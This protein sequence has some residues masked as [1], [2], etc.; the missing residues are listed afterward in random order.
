MGDN[1]TITKLVPT[2]I[3]LLTGVAIAIAG[4]GLHS[5]AV[6]N[7]GTAWAWGN[8]GTGQLGDTTTTQRKAPVQ[9]NTI[10]GVTAVSAG[11]N[12]SMALKSDNTVWTWG[13]NSSGELG[14]GTTNQAMAPVQAVGVSGATE[15][16]AGNNFSVARTSGDQILTWGSEGPGK[17]GDGNS[18]IR[19][20]P[21]QISGLSGVTQ[22]SA[23]GFHTLA[24]LS[25]GTVKALGDNSVGQLGDGTT[26]NRL[27]PVSV[28]G[29]TSITA[30]SAGNTHSL[31]RKNDGTV[32]AWGD[33]SSGQLGNNTTTQQLVP[34]QVVGVGGTGFLTGIA[35]ISASGS[36][37]YSLAVDS[38]GVVY[39][40]GFNGAG[41]LGDGTTTTRQAPVAVTGL[42]GV[43]TAVA[44]GNNHSLAL[45]NDGTVWA[46]GNNFQGQ[47][48]DGTVTN[49]LVPV[50]VAG[51]TGITA[52]S[53]GN[54]VSLAR[55][56]DGSMWA[57]G[58]NTAGQLGLGGIFQQF[59]PAENQNLPD[60]VS[61]SAGN[62]YSLFMIQIGSVVVG[63]FGTNS[64]GQLGN[65]TIG[66]GT[67]N[68]IPIL[69]FGGK[70]P[71][72]VSANSYS[73]AVMTDGTVWGWG[74]DNSG[75]LGDS[76][77]IFNPTP[78]APVARGVAD[79]TVTKS[80]GADFSAGSP[81]TYTITV[82]NVGQASMSGPTTVVDTLPAG[83]SFSSGSG[84][85]WV[86][87]GVSVG[88]SC[89]HS[90]A[91]GA[92]ASSVITLNVNT[93]AL[94]FPD[95]F[96]LVTVS[97]AGDVH[98]LNNT[99]SDETNAP[100]PT[101]VTLTP[102][103]SPN[104]SIFG[105][106][107]SLSATVTPSG[108]TGYV[109]FAD[110]AT[111][112]GT[113]P[114]SSGTAHLNTLLMTPGTRLLGAVFVPDQPYTY[115]YSPFVMHTVN[116][117]PSASLTP[118]ASSPLVLGGSRVGYLVATGDFN[119][120][121][122]MDI[123][124]VDSQSHTVTIYLGNGIGGFTASS[125]G[126]FQTGSSPVA[127]LV[128]DLNRDGKPD[129]AIANQGVNTLTVLFG[130]GAGGFA[131]APR[132]PFAVGFNPTSLVVGNINED[133]T[134]V[135]YVAGLASTQFTRLKRD[136]FGNFFTDTISLPSGSRSGIAAADFNGD[137]RFDVAFSDIAGTVGILLKADTDYNPLVNITS[138]IHPQGI[139]AADLNGDGKMDLVT[140]DATGIEVLIGNGSGGF[141][142]ATGSPFVP[143]AG[144][145]TGISSVSIGDFNGDGKPDLFVVRTPSSTS[146]GEVAIMLGNGSGGFA[147]AVGSGYASKSSN[148]L[149]AVVANFNGDGRTDVAVTDPG[150]DAVVVLQGL[151][152]VVA[153]VSVV[154]NS[155]AGAL[156][157]FSG[158]YAA[159]KGY[160]DLQWVQML[161]GATTSSQPYCLVHYDVQGNKFWLFNDVQGFFAG[162]ISPGVASNLLQGS[163]CALNTSGSSVSESGVDLTINAA[164]VFKQAVA[165]K[166]FMRGLTFEGV[167]TGWVQQGT[168]T[169]VAAALGTM[170]VA[171][172]SGSVTHGTQ[173]IFTLTY[174]DPPGFAGAA[175]GWEQF[176]VATATDGGG[177]PFCYVHYDRGG[178]GL[179]MYSGDVGYFLGPVTPGTASSLLTSSACSI[180]TAGATVA[181]TSGNLV[182]TVPVTFKAPMVRGNKLFQRTLDVLN[183]D[184][185]FEQTG[186]WTVN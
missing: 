160:R 8:N 155:G 186:T 74:F 99:A 59:T 141:T 6:K 22:A 183:R 18:D 53:A 98:A 102:A 2:Q 101:G 11:N 165:V 56:S 164:V 151:P 32:W 55:K 135:V 63:G 51:L 157:T 104:P 167:D 31:A 17:L 61:V 13:D 146:K 50:Q 7:D 108:A 43:F 144:S 49:H 166:I 106:N 180:N 136:M 124:V 28:S 70:T 10:T 20:V 171:P 162:P 129:L 178:N 84:T 142:E 46:W 159:A 60:V 181:N 75:Q 117:I 90:G 123:A 177:N 47:L 58:A 45:R 140:Y 173:Q 41:Q 143:G 73:L 152:P 68:P 92:G 168:W 39:A 184:T 131:P 72:S 125:G 89:T 120:D 29:I 1:T 78:T 170:T 116:A 57:W 153:P 83:M 94:M 66:L 158:R 133:G 154:P 174:P 126:P 163:L 172:S 5:L 179:W 150:N 156:Q 148:L 19:P 82:T 27:T 64:T 87:S 185:G 88:A 80:H 62:G 103:P 93:T 15:I 128:A 24:L 25:G 114:V 76:P 38:T 34:V 14:D 122:K 169:T 111:L 85:G 40:W 149:H 77:E 21:I 3:T 81:G 121:G 16:S 86:C 176:L 12:H 127:L 30:I 35:G 69:G 113:A 110:G 95:Q 52:I 138:T 65:G 36:N 54:Q 137:G 118:F 115:S 79:L 48:G 71:S 139:V 119:S 105:Q 134:P 37:D 26:T 147:Q 97:N 23:G 109:V 132:S 96:N 130:N 107:L 4:G 91:I 67:P 161:F 145:I 182:V 9:V 175:F 42:S 100:T 33:N 44:A 112:F